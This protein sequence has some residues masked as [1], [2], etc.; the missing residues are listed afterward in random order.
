MNRS[1]TTT[2]AGKPA[3]GLLL[4]GLIAIV[5]CRPAS[6]ATPTRPAD[7]PA[8]VFAPARHGRP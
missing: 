8:E 1:V 5:R 6:P 4:L 7:L 2:I 3:A